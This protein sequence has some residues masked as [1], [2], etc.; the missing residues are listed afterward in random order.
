M[1]ILAPGALA[2]VPVVLL[3]LDGTLVDSGPGILD[4]LGRAFAECGEELPPPEV[5][6]TFVGPPLAESFQGTLGLSAERAEKLEL[7][8]SEH[9]QV[10][11]LL[12]APPYPG[13]PELLE[14]LARDGRTMAVATNKP[15]TTARRLLAHQGLDGD[16]ALIAGTDRATGRDDKAAVVRSV[17]VRLGLEARTTAT[18]RGAVSG[19]PAV[20][21]GDRI[22]DAEGA[23]VHGLP[24]V[25]TG[26]GYGGAVERESGWPRAETVADLAAMLLR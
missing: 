5:L 24:A 19:A 2:D 20:M 4:G 8:Y 26:W 14:G 15:E 9:Y 22:H 16:L 23:A 10:G 3:D 21:I 18:D 6:R 7:A 1:S 13:I 25:L 12:A 11:G 17:L